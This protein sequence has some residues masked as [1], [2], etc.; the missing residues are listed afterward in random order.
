[1]DFSLAD[2][3]QAAGG[4]GV[5]VGAVGW[6]IRELG[7]SYNNVLQQLIE[8]G[9]IAR[10]RA[11]AQDLRIDALQDAVEECERGRLADR[12]GHANERR[13]LERTAEEALGTA[14]DVRLDLERA[15]ATPTEPRV[16]RRER[17]PF[18]TPPARPAVTEALAAASTADE[19]AFVRTIA[20]MTA[21]AVITEEADSEA[22]D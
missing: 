4:G 22:K 1:M 11:D 3:G 8:Q 16:P 12:E 10:A 9:K 2:I 13:E 7:R 17:L 6:V 14:V 18:A 15:G 20:T 19:D 21:V 5:L